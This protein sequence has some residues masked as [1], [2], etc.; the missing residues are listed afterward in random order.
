MV[1]Y[2]LTW[3]IARKK[4]SILTLNVWFF[5]W[6]S[7]NS[8]KKKPLMLFKLEH[9]FLETNQFL[10]IFRSLLLFFSSTI[11]FIIPSSLQLPRIPGHLL[12]MFKTMFVGYYKSQRWILL[13]Q[14][15]GH[16]AQH[17]GLYN[18]HLGSSQV[19]TRKH[20]YAPVCFMF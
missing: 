5:F 2:R 15:M 17:S 18:S 1:Y 7:N 3:L 11:A 8:W 14:A 13:D 19:W 9:P 4:S 16:L 6:R 10:F 20:Y 12:L